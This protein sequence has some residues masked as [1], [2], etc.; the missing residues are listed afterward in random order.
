MNGS[1]QNGA[2]TRR[3]FLKRTALIW[4]ALATANGVGAS[5]WK[6]IFA[7]E[8]SDGPE[9]TADEIAAA[10]RVLSETS[11]PKWSDERL[12]AAL[13]IQR[14]VD[15]LE[16]KD[17]ND[18]FNGSP[19]NAARWIAERG[20]L[21]FLDAGF[22]KILREVPTT[23]VAEGTV[24]FWQIYNMGY[25]VK[26]PTQTFAIDVRH[27]RAPELEPLVDFTLITHNHGDHFTRSF[28]QA[29]E[30]AGK[31]VVSNFLDNRWKTGPNG[32]EYEFGDA[33]IR[34]NLVDHNAKLRR[35]VSTYEI[36]CGAATGNRVVYHV[37][38][39]C[40]FAQLTPEKPVDVFIPHLA[41]GLDVPKCVK[42][43]LKPKLTLL[44]HI[45][46]LAHDIDKWRWSYKYGLGICAKCASDS[47][48]LPVWGEKIVVGG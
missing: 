22:D 39:A 3:E 32:G 1:T 30:A 27:R 28:I 36:D 2:A 26:T 5:D 14:S 6:R 4:G 46:E 9:P 18:Y 33:K 11:G 42:E 10:I 45:L 17:F 19:E 16:A 13:T 44:S 47:V 12:K 23:E 38:D 25:V 20:V 48:L 15:R 8:F 31:P 43:T 34:V 35:F 24:V 41:V 29:M 21:R 7:A 40:N 37:G